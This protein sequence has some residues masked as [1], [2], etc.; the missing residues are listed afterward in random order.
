VDRQVARDLTG[1][2]TRLTLLELPELGQGWKVHY[3]LFGHQG[4]T[5]AAQ[6]EIQSFGGVCIK[7]EE[8]DKVLSRV[9]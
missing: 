5:E 4:F 7:L 3:A 9:D 1:E 6:N 2:K 8:L